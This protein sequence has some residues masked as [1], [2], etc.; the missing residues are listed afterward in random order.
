MIINGPF[1]EVGAFIYHNSKKCVRSGSHLYEFKVIEM[2][3]TV[4]ET[5]QEVGP[6]GK[7]RM[8]PKARRVTRQIPNFIQKGG[9]LSP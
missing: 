2:L 1:Y 4:F 9:G 5:V 3:D 7:V 6:D 8:L